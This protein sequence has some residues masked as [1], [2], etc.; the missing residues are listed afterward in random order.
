[1]KS[2]VK[3]IHLATVVLL[4]V[5]LF[6]ACQKMDR[7]PL[8]PIIEDPTPPPYNDLKGYW[9]FENNLNDEGE[10][11]FTTTA[12]KTAFV[13]GVSGQGIMI[14]DAGYVLVKAFG[15][16]TKYPNEFV[17]IPADTLANLGSYTIAFWMNEATSFDNG[18]QGVFALA[19]KSQFWGN[20]ELFFENYKNAADPTEAFLKIHMY[21]D[22]RPGGGEQWNELKIPGVFG[23]WSQI[24][25]TYD[26]ATSQINVYANGQTTSIANKVLDGGN[27]GPIKFKDF[28][29]MVM[30]SFA[31]Q[32]TPSLTNHGPESWAKSFNGALDQFRVYNR[33][34]SLSEVQ[35]L[36]TSKK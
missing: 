28:N 35:D 32:T 4:S 1:M 25:V 24:A 33:A 7:P 20:L 18:A 30:G 21:N 17:G 13:T 2:I 36:Y 11:G 26:A 19:N 16:T 14:E 5:I 8:G 10:S 29:G 22:N 9:Q 12:T 34:L 6:S 3:N 27:Y 31:F 23:Q 15:D